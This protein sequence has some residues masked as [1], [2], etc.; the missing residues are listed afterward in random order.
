MFCLIEY[1]LWKILNFKRSEL[2]FIFSSVCLH[3]HITCSQVSSCP[4][5]APM[6]HYFLQQ[7][8]FLHADKGCVRVL[9]VQCNI[10][11]CWDL[12]PC[13]QQQTYNGWSVHNQ[14]IHMQSYEHTSFTHP[15]PSCFDQW[16]GLLCSDQWRGLLSHKYKHSFT[17]KYFFL[18]SNTHIISSCTHI[19]H[20]Y[21]PSWPLNAHSSIWLSVGTF[22]GITGR[23]MLLLL[24]CI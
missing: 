8:L 15:I 19:D 23:N 10:L 13:P 20:W 11:H 1:V 5:W 21:S 17:Q 14:G 9:G 2:G 18:F 7:N 3:A 4:L 12:V 6:A 16:R 24:I 22:I